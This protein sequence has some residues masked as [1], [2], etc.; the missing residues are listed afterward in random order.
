MFKVLQQV[1]NFFKVDRAMYGDW[2]SSGLGCVEVGVD[3][4]SGTMSYGDIDDPRNFRGCGQ[5]VEKI[6]RHVVG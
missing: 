4:D 5:M 6:L 3:G 1:R 2:E